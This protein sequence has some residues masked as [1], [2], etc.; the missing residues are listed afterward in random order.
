M[1]SGYAVSGHPHA[2]DAVLN[3]EDLLPWLPILDLLFLQVQ[4]S[5]HCTVLYGVDKA[6]FHSITFPIYQNI[7]NQLNTAILIVFDL[8]MWSS[9]DHSLA[10]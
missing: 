8:A 7:Y 9:R 3:K 4:E 6:F 1:Q 2:V 10:D 5:L